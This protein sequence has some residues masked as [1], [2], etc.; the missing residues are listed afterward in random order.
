MEY[1]DIFQVP[2]LF[3]SRASSGRL[4]FFFPDALTVIQVR[5]G[6][7]E[8]TTT[9]RTARDRRVYTNNAAATAEV[10]GGKE[11]QIVYFVLFVCLFAC[12]VRW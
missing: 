6:R 12:L 3:L 2:A 1:V 5:I 8:S 7:E 9:P 11:A 10:H 4:F